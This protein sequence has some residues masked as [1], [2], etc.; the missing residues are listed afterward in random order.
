M[1]VRMPVVSPTCQFANVSSPTYEV[2][3]KSIRQRQMSVRQR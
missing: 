1:S 2:V 3:T